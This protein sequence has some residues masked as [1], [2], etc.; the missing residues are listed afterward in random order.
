RAVWD[1]VNNRWNQWVL[2]YTQSRQLDLLRNIGFESPSWEDLGYVL[3][4]IV[5][6]VSLAGAGWTLWDRHRQDPWLLLLHRAQRRLAKAGLTV[7]A[8]T[9]PRQMAAL[10]EQRGNAPAALSEWLLKLE[11]WRYAPSQTAHTKTAFQQLQRSFR[12]LPWPTT[13]Y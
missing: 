2:N 9:P 13:L 6:A 7:P 11:A 10:L 5:V 1:A 12:H 3:I 8:N 4:G